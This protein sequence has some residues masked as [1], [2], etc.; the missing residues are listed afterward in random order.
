MRF[1]A[2]FLYK[3]SSILLQ[4][5]YCSFLTNYLIM[6][7]SIHLMQRLCKSFDAKQ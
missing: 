3:I 1:Y 5:R 2:L 7:V 4:N 6:G